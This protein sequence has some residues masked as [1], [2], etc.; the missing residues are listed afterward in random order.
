MN[1]KEM[2]SWMSVSPTSGTGNKTITVTVQENGDVDTRE[3]DLQI[4]GG[5]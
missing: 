4:S 1:V 2:A 3:V 5:V